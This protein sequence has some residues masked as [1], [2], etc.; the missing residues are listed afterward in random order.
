VLLA[1]FISQVRRATDLRPSRITM[2]N[3]GSSNVILYADNFLLRPW[4]IEDAAWYVE[5]RDEEVF[6]WTNEKRDLTIEET[7]KAIKSLDNSPDAIC[8]AIVDRNN[9]ELLGNIALAF[10]EGNRKVAEIM[11]WLAPWGRGRGIATDSV[12]L[13]CQWA[14][15]SLRLERVTLKTHSENIRSQSVAKRVGF[16]R[17]EG[18]HESGLDTISLWFELASDNYVL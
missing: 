13:L 9:M 10:R 5:S 12:K 1:L 16:Q 4:K 8:F 3:R 7:E 11:Y 15:N 18:G 14:F 17:Q 6:K 2:K